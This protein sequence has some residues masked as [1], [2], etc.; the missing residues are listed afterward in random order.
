MAKPVKTVFSDAVLSPSTGA[1]DLELEGSV[2]PLTG[3]ISV[4]GQKP[5]RLVGEGDLNSYI[6]SL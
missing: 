4:N 3:D 6:E 2:K 1:S 5:V